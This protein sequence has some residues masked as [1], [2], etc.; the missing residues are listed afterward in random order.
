MGNVNTRRMNTETSRNPSFES[1]SNN[2][3]H[4]TNTTNQSSPSHL[5]GPLLSSAPNSESLF[6]ETILD[7]T[8]TPTTFPLS[9]PRY[10]R[11]P[12]P[13]IQM[14]TTLL[15]C[16]DAPFRPTALDMHTFSPIMHATRRGGRSDKLNLEESV[17]MTAQ[18]KDECDKKVKHHANVDND[19]CC[20][21]QHDNL[22]KDSK[23]LTCGHR[24]HLQCFKDLVQHS[25]KN[26]QKL[27]CPMCRNSILLNK[28]QQDNVP[29]CVMVNRHSHRNLDEDDPMYFYHS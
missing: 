13:Q 18:R 2:N 9:Y 19:T 22:D 23:V 8:H 3:E 26:S 7:T 14:S 27:K 11:T 25:R 12:S 28:H 15:E 24:L 29:R 17:H 5:N 10:P 20:I 6:M 21:C 4:I 1:N 16:P